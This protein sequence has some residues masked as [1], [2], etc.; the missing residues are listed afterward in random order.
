MAF[1]S[2]S[3][4]AQWGL[5]APT[6]VTTTFADEEVNIQATGSGWNVIGTSGSSDSSDSSDS[7]GSSAT[8]RGS[9]A[10]GIG[11]GLSIGQL[12]GGIYSTYSGSKLAGDLLKTQ[13]H[14]NENNAKIAQMGYESAMRAGESEIQKISMNAGA[15]K[16]K[17]KAAMA[18]NG[19]KLGVGSAADVTAST[20]VMKKLDMNTAHQN[21]LASAFGYSVRQ[22]NYEGQAKAQGYAG[23]YNQG[24]GAVGMTIGSALE[25]VGQVADRWYKYFGD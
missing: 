14:I 5:H 12:I 24:A 2:L 10:R 1:G 7:S 18:A 19:I 25:D 8:G 6:G 23:S 20:E 13:Q 17:Q 21:A 16:S 15:V 4:N 22:S 11:L 3:Q 9:L